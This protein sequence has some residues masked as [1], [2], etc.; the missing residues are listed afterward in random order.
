METYIRKLIDNGDEDT[1]NPEYQAFIKWR[2]QNI[3]NIKNILV[4]EKIMYKN[5]MLG[6][7]F[8][9]TN[10]QYLTSR[11]WKR[12]CDLKGYKD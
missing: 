12:Y 1:L 5:G 10:A 8:F 11:Y 7:A 2:Q 6:M 3:R 4:K 9:K